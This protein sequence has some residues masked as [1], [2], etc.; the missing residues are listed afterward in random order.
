MANKKE[1][2]VT[3]KVADA[4]AFKSGGTAA[5]EKEAI[6]AACKAAKI[7]TTKNRGANFTP[8]AG[9][10]FQIDSFTAA[11]FEVPA[12]KDNE[13]NVTK[14]AEKRGWLRI[15]V[16]A[17]GQ[18]YAI[19]LNRLQG[20]LFGASYW[21]K[22]HG[23]QETADE[24]IEIADKYGLTLDIDAKEFAVIDLG[25]YAIANVPNDFD[26]A[27]SYLIDARR[28]AT[29]FMIVATEVRKS[30]ENTFKTSCIITKK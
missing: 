14:P 5:D 1:N 8:P 23:M 3:A 16:I 6:V 15:N 17:N 11:T 13:G 7:D 18:I 19:S 9:V 30:G 22:K 25:A 12:K 24:L 2:K 27:V 4:I 20:A 28:K 10:E 21:N 26:S 29:K